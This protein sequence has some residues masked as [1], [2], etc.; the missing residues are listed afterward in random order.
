MPIEESM[1]DTTLTDGCWDCECEHDFIHAKIRE[2]ECSKCGATEEDQ[3][4]SHVV[5]VLAIPSLRMTGSEYAE[6]V[7]LCPFCHSDQVEGGTDSDYQGDS[8]I[9]S[10]TCN[11][12][13]SGWRE[14]YTLDGWIEESDSPLVPDTW[15]PDTRATDKIKA[16]EDERDKFRTALEKI[17]DMVK[18]GDLDPE[19]SDLLG[20]ATEVE[21][22]TIDEAY[23]TATSCIDLARNTLGRTSE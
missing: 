23:S 16:L 2:K 17:A 6:H 5:E 7:G 9:S 22:W 18:P 19:A 21:D 12:C 13:G 15:H 11:T 8:M 10:S 14:N 20:E 4:D 1:Q 3:P